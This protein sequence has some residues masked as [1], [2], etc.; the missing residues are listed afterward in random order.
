MN[1]GQLAY[2]TI[3]IWT[4]HFIAICFTW[5]HQNTLPLV[6]TKGDEYQPTH[7]WNHRYRHHPFIAVCFTWS[8]QNTPSLWLETS[9]W[10]PVNSPIKPSL[11][12]S[13]ISSRSALAD[14]IKIPCLWLKPKA[15]NT[16]QL[17]NETIAIWTIHFIVICF[18]WWQKNTSMLLVEIK[19]DEPANSP[20]TPSLSELY[21]SLRSALA[22]RNKYPMPLVETKGD[23]YQP[24]SL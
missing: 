13:S 6:E 10:I 5:S 9:L 19:S 1:T 24:T 14:H 2:K 15:M 18:S 23:E 22:D 4:I 7:Q 17:I 11:S 12:T 21:I 8:H 3:V 20:M 16:S